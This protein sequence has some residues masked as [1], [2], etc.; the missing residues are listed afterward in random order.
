VTAGDGGAGIAAGSFLQ[1][2]NDA[3]A[4]PNGAGR[5]FVTAP[6]ASYGPGYNATLS[7]NA[8]NAIEWT[9]NLRYAPQGQAG[10]FANGKPSLAVVLG[11]TGPDLTTASG[12]ALAIGHNGQS[13]RIQLDRFTGGLVADANLTTVVAA[14]TANLAGASD[15]ASV[16]VR[17]APATSQ[18]SLYVRDDG[19]A[20]WSDPSAGVAALTGTAADSTYANVPLT[21]YGFYWG[22]G[23]AGTQ[24]GQ[25]DNYAVTLTPVP[26]PGTVL[27]L[28]ALGLGAA[29]LGRRLRRG[30]PPA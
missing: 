13:D 19:A 4:S 11:A 2:T 6:T 12:Y 23:S 20:G 30:R 8:V 15:Y 28:G 14:S 7:A 27:G 26:E 17:Y 5:V 3:T 18:W 21:S 25:F 29:A 9:V 1:L 10:G 16:R 24:L 22:Y